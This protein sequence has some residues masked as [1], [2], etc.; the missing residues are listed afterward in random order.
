MKAEDLMV[1]NWVA[2]EIQVDDVDNHPVYKQIPM[3]VS[4]LS[5]GVIELE[6]AG[7]LGNQIYSV[8]PLKLTPEILEESG[9]VREEV[10][11]AKCQYILY[12][13]CSPGYRPHPLKTVYVTI[14]DYIGISINYQTK[15]GG[16]KR[17]DGACQYVHELQNAM[18]QCEVE[19]KIVARK[20]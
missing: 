15:A 19:H 5:H 16:F 1:G 14:S 18:K 10:T 3:R 4:S 11:F 6:E 13:P 7:E 9:F 2:V 12:T 20:A 17:Y 8:V